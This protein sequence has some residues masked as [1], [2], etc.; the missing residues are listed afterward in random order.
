MSLKT[1]L[2]RAASRALRSADSL[3]VTATYVSTNPGAASYNPATGLQTVPTTT[4]SIRVIL[5]AILEV[6]KDQPRKIA[7]NT[8]KAIFNREGF[9]FE[10]KVEDQ[11]T[12]TDGDD[13]GTWEV[14]SV[15][16]EPSISI[17][18]LEV[19]RA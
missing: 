3:A 10:A 18:V 15:L 1:T 9:P 2:N 4:A 19:R 8:K 6:Q 17:Y 16:S 11:I 12:L 14:V 13:A 5:V 7:P